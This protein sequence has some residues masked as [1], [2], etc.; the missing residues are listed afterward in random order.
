MC[1]GYFKELQSVFQGNFKG[2]LRKFQGCFKKVLRKLKGGSGEFWGCFIGVLWAHK[3]YFKARLKGVS[4]EFQWYLKGCF[5]IASRKLQLYVGSLG[6][7]YMWVVGCLFVVVIIRYKTPVL[8]I[9]IYMFLELILE[10]D[11]FQ[12][13]AWFH[14]PFVRATPPTPPSPQWFQIGGHEDS[15]IYGIMWNWLL[16]VLFATNIM[17]ISRNSLS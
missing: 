11:G 2:V 12:D 10:V 16:M 1:W 3:R 15:F 8:K 6:D 17:K 4:R 5:E 7:V 9:C 14:Y 13:N